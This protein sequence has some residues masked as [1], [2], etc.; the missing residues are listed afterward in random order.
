[1][2]VILKNVTCFGM[3]QTDTKYYS[4]SGMEIWG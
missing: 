3:Q 1:M 2:L 4:K